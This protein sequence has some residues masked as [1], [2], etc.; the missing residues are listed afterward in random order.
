M[1]DIDT[2][3]FF[4]DDGVSDT[5]PS[6]VSAP[7][8]A[9]LEAFAG[10]MSNILNSMTL[11]FGDEIVA[12]GSGALDYFFGGPGYEARL[13]QIRGLRK[14]FRNEN[15]IA[16]TLGDI[17]GAFQL[18]TSI[19]GV[20][21]GVAPATSSI[22]SKTAQS[23]K[24]LFS[25]V[26]RGAAE[27]AVYGT[28]YGFG[29]GEGNLEERLSSAAE[30]L[31]SS[32]I[33]GG[34]AG[35]LQGGLRGTARAIDEASDEFLAQALNVQRSDLKRAGR[36][37][38]SSGSRASPLKI[39]IQGVKERGLFKGATNTDAIIAR[40]ERAIDQL[41]SSIS[42]LLNKATKAQKSEI[43]PTFRNAMKFLDDHPYEAEQLLGQFEKRQNTIA[44]LWDGSLNSLQTAKQKLY[45]I[46]Y[47]GTNESRAFDQAIA[48]DLKEVIEQ[49][50][51]KDIA[52]QIKALNKE[53][54]QHL[55][56]RELLEKNKLQEEMPGGIAKALRRAIVSPIGGG[57]LGV[58]T[59]IYTDDPKY[60]ALGLAG[61][62]ATTRAGQLI[63][64]DLASLVAPKVGSIAKTPA[65]ALFSAIKSSEEP[66]NLGNINESQS[67]DSNQFFIDESNMTEE[68][69]LPKE[70]PTSGYSPV[71][72]EGQQLPFDNLINAVVKQESN[73]NPKAIG[74]KTKYG[75][76]KG[77]MQIL[78]STGKW[79]MKKLGRD[80]KDW[81]PFD[82][83]LNKEAGAWYLNYLNQK[84]GEPRLALAAYNWGEG[85]LSKLMKRLNTK[86]FDKIFSSLPKETRGYVTNIT[87]NLIMEV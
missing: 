15:P 78:D 1:V 68:Q 10:G 72:F 5:A 59:S 8:Q 11:G 39:A 49:G 46:A 83:Q 30:L 53:E 36:F 69:S 79:I 84:F 42:G 60:A 66:T 2:N 47:K 19:F 85:N 3:Q 6:P 35:T 86:D 61:G 31:P 12:G 22:F 37:T 76:A 38:R 62:A 58:G 20:A 4:I 65:A 77:A 9:P 7:N 13:D 48:R 16:A 81:N 17:G 87:K 64:S 24:N 32:L 54:G 75:T 29:E 41:G 52:A 82:E 71:S 27:G 34:A 43:V 55:A 14:D 73:N 26:G 67:F 74:P 23:A 70:E 18:P 33:F 56:I 63:L 45:K 51:P 21:K 57:A 40:N 28:A 50:A 25:N 44:Q 80:P